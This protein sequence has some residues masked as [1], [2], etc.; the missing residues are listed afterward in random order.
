MLLNLEVNITAGSLTSCPGRCVFY[1]GCDLF[2]RPEHGGRRRAVDA[3]DWHFRGGGDGA[4]LLR[5][6]GSVMVFSA[7]RLSVILVPR[8][9]GCTAR[10]SVQHGCHTAAAAPLPLLGLERP[11]R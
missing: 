4:A 2:V 1:A 6:D 9:D 11:R 8:G 3:L 5:G 10:R 7:A